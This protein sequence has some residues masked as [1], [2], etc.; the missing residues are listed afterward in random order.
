MRDFTIFYLAI[1]L[2][3]FLGVLS[4]GYFGEEFGYNIGFVACGILTLL[5]L[6]PMLKTK[7]REFLKGSKT[8]I[9]KRALT[10]IM[11]FIIVGL[12]WG[13]YEISKY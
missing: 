9:G 5:S 7:E 2:G 6:I 13:V 1:N 8:S 11:T 12:F 3:S 4:I 10:I